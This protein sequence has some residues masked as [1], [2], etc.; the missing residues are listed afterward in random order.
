MRHPAMLHCN[1]IV[2][3]SPVSDRMHTLDLAAP[4]ASDRGGVGGLH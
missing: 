1:R 2:R 3:Q 4:V